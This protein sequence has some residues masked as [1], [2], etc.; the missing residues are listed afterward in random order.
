GGAGKRRD[1]ACPWLNLG[2]RINLGALEA[3]AVIHID[4]L[5]LS[6]ELKCAQAGLA[7]AVAGAARAAEGQLDLR[8]DGAGVD[9][10]DAGRQVAHRGL[11]GVGIAREDAA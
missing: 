11:D 7:V 8:A 1:A 3:A 4:R 5:P 10:D 6:E 9:V 2:L